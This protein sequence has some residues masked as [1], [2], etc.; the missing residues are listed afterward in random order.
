MYPVP[1]L[2]CSDFW[3]LLKQALT[4]SPEQVETLSN[5][6]VTSPVVIQDSM[7]VNLDIIGQSVNPVLLC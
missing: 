6:T 5:N 7:S 3:V 1:Q 4:D 2:S